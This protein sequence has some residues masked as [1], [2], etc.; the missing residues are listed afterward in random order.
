MDVIFTILLQ[1]CLCQQ[2][3]PVP[4]NIISYHTGNVYHD[5][6]RNSPVLVYLIRRQIQM[7]QTRVQQYFFVFNAMYYVVLFVVYTHMINEQ[8]VYLFHW[9]WFCN[10]WQSINTKGACVTWKCNIRISQQILYSRNSKTEISFATCA[11][12][13]NTSLWQRTLW[14]I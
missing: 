11:Y 13:W 10:T 6:V 2:C 3:A 5:V 4:H 9:Y 1:I 12:Y 14:S 8:Y 7:Q